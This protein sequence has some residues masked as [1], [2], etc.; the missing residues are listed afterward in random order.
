MNLCC[1]I[2]QVGYNNLSIILSPPRPPNPVVDLLEFKIHI[3]H[4]FI[5]STSGSVLIWLEQTT[6]PSPFSEHAGRIAFTWQVSRVPLLDFLAAL[7]TPS[8]LPNHVCP[9]ARAVWPGAVHHRVKPPDKTQREAA[10]LALHNRATAVRLLPGVPVLAQYLSSST[11]QPR[12]DSGN[13]LRDLSP[14]AGKSARVALP[15]PGKTAA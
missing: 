1:F 13:K 15:R 14:A 3:N 12:L 5:Q 8:L 4:K 9:R 7:L 11:R 6:P 10:A 2:D